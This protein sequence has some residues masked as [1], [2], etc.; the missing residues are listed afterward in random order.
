MILSFSNFQKKQIKYSVSD[1]FCYNVD[2]DDNTEIFKYLNL[3]AE[4][5]VESIVGYP[6]QYGM[7]PVVKSIDDLKKVIKALDDECVKKFGNP[8]T[9][10]FKIGDKVRILPKDDN[11]RYFPTYLSGMQKYSGQISTVCEIENGSVKLANDFWW[12]PKALELVDEKEESKTI[13][14]NQ[15][16]DGDYIIITNNR[17]IKYIV[18]FKCIKNSSIIRHATYN[19]STEEF[20]FSIYGYWGELSSVSRI[21]YATEEEKQLLDSKLLEKGYRWNNFTKEIEGIDSSDI[22]INIDKPETQFEAELNLFPTKK[23][24]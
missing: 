19:L 21:D 2:N 24:Y 3:N 4:D 1:R 15:V 13:D 5:F 14:I 7:W 11:L 8:N 22:S 10:K 23:H 12:D 16:R 18:L 6:C 17:G 9:P 20:Y